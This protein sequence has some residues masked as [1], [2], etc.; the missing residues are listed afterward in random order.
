MSHRRKSRSRTHRR[1]SRSY[2]RST[3]RFSRTR[4]RRLNQ[5]NISK[6]TFDDVITQMKQLFK[7]EVDSEHDVD[8]VFKMAY[9]NPA[10][11]IDHMRGYRKLKS[12]LELFNP[13]M[14][15]I[16]EWI[17]LDCAIVYKNALE[18][19][20]KWHDN[21]KKYY[22]LSEFDKKATAITNFRIALPKRVTK[23]LADHKESM[24]LVNRFRLEKSNPI[25]EFADWVR[26]N[27]QIIFKIIKT[28][29]YIPVETE[30]S[31]LLGFETKIG[32][33]LETFE[34]GN[35]KKNN[36]SASIKVVTDVL[37]D[38]FSTLNNSII[39][40]PYISFLPEHDLKWELNRLSICTVDTKKG[41]KIRFQDD[42]VKPENKVDYFIHQCQRY[43]D[44]KKLIID[45]VYDMRH[46][47]V[48][49]IV[50]ADK[51]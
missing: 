47:M 32:N 39:K 43:I 50:Y 42:E 20:R 45:H 34:K 37:D 6:P 25:K 33:T 26:S 31:I 30:L 36:L 16:L 9:R 41:K 29:L 12:K 21:S 2:K 14:D 18:Q 7:T 5:L 44:F 51:D 10:Y 17:P 23:V 4:F 19:V 35:Y 27:Y 22:S 15:Q 28:Y 13:Y 11:F 46:L 8:F 3:R 1:K 40:L 49:F 48:R 38:F 24:R